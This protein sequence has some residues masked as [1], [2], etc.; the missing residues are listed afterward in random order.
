M[1]LNSTRKFSLKNEEDF[2]KI[3]ETLPPDLIS[4]LED[5]TNDNTMKESL[6]EKVIYRYY[7]DREYRFLFDRKKPHKAVFLNN[8]YIGLFKPQDIKLVDIDLNGDIK[9]ELEQKQN[10]CNNCKHDRENEHKVIKPKDGTIE[11]IE[12]QINKYEELIRN[13]NENETNFRE[14]RYLKSEKEMREKDLRDEKLVMEDNEKKD[15]I[16]EIKSKKVLVLCATNSTYLRQRW[17][18]ISKDFINTNEY[19]PYYTG[20][21]ILDNPPFRYKGDLNT[22]NF[23]SIFGEEFFDCI[24]SEHCPYIIFKIKQLTSLIK[25]LKKGGKFILPDY[26]KGSGSIFI[27]ELS[28]FFSSVDN[29]GLYLCYNK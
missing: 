28:N 17:I 26:S 3:I 24:I 13:G 23:T 18:D 19:T 29:N 4:F 5:D 11:E 2:Q 16:K 22:L 21:D 15:E 1:L 27:E 14:L 8:K 20:L 7:G 9:V 25:L 10:I 6:L 12:E